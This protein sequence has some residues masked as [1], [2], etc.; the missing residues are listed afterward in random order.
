MQFVDRWERIRGAEY[1]LTAA[2]IEA[3][4]SERCQRPQLVA[5]RN[6]PVTHLCGQIVD[7]AKEPPKAN[8][9]PVASGLSRVARD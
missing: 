3:G 5:A 7:I 2:T 9:C 6:A 8:T 1:L 4:S